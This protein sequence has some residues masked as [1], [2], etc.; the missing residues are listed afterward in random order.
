[1]MF[2]PCDVQAMDDRF[3]GAPPPSSHTLGEKRVQESL[4]FWTQS[5]K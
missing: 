1:M 2:E 4:I 5:I 3:S